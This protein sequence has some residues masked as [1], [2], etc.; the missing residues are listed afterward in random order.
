MAAT[1]AIGMAVCMGPVLHECRSNSS[2]NECRTALTYTYGLI[3]RTCDVVEFICVK[4]RTNK[5]NERHHADEY[6]AL[7]DL[8]SPALQSND[9]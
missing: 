4:K 1:I 9:C 3:L 8:R 5:P 7:D 6:T 2:Y